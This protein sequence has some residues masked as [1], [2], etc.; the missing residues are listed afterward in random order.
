MMSIFDEEK[1]IEFYEIRRPLLP[2]DPEDATPESVTPEPTTIEIPEKL[3]RQ[4]DVADF[5]N[6]NVTDMPE[7]LQEAVKFVR[8]REKELSLSA[9]LNAI[10]LALLEW[11]RSAGHATLQDLDA[12]SAAALAFKPAP[13]DIRRR[14]E[15][16]VRD[17]ADDQTLSARS[18]KFVDAFEGMYADRLAEQREIEERREQTL[19][20]ER[21]HVEMLRSAFDSDPEL[22]ALGEIYVDWV[23]R[24]DDSM[25]F[26]SQRDHLR[27]IVN[28][29]LHAAAPSFNSRLLPVA[30]AM[31]RGIKFT[32]LVPSIAFGGERPLV[33]HAGF[34]D[35]DDE[36]KITFDQP[37]AAKV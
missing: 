21:E 5:I 3:L 9:A 23:S 15:N 2:E 16:S 31:L 14:V 6:V 17:F 22:R 4:L 34:L 35:P 32:R 18:P 20:R 24:R 7:P 36:H 33:S 29:K 25:Q 8:K 37:Y 1:P 19:T 10:R 13:E 28:A 26:Q 12:F 27:K 11:S 30:F